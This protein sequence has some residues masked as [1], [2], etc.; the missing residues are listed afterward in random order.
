MDHD[1]S[2]SVKSQSIGV[3]ISGGSNLPAPGAENDFI[4]AN[5]GLNWIKKTLVEIRI[6]LGLGSA[7]YTDST[8]YAVSDHAH[9]EDYEPAISMDGTELIPIIQIG[10]NKTATH[11]LLFTKISQTAI[12]SLRARYVHPVFAGT[13]VIGN[14]GKKLTASPPNPLTPPGS[15]GTQNAMYNTFFGHNAGLKICLDLSILL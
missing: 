15:D 10:V 1:I 7:A 12:D 8:D 14:G 11:N 5:T 13:L 6:I 9:D 2:I 3:N 4:V